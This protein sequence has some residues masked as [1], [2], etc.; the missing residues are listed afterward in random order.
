MRSPGGEPRLFVGASGGT[1]FGDD[2]GYNDFALGGLLR[3]GAFNQ[4]ELRGDNYLLAQG[5]A[6]FRVLR[7]PDVLGG[8]GYMGAWLESGSAFDEWDEARVQW[9]AS[10]GFVL[11][12]ILG[13]VFLGGSV[14]LNDGSG[15]FYV[16]VGPFFFR[17]SLLSR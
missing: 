8:N 5:G 16:N 6:L 3:L 17:Q 14:S 1:S 13:P 4:G 10:G 15:R 2:P 12:T 7:L 9:Q 11:E